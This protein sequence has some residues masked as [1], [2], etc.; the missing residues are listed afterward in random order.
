MLIRLAEPADAMAVARVH[1]R[2]WQVAYK[3][4]M[5]QGYL[6]Q[7]R[8]EERAARYTFGSLDP[9]SPTTVVAVE[10]TQIYGFATVALARDQDVPGS[11]ELYALYVDPEWWGR[12]VGAQLMSAARNRLL[13]L[14]FQQAVLWALKGNSRAERFYAADQWKPDGMQRTDTV[15]GVVVDEVRYRCTLITE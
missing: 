13:D 3:G 10:N 2:S 1:V 11:G 8:P 9:N 14:G 15:W 7:L 12:G 6:D 5:P 4:L